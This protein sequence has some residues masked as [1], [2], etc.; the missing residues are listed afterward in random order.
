MQCAIYCENGFERDINGCEICQ[1]ARP[2]RRGRYIFIFSIE[3]K[4]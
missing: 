4:K 1:C 2:A 3:Q